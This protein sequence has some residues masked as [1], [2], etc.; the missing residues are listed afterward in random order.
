MGITC[1]LTGTTAPLAL[2]EGQKL[3]QATFHERYEAMP[4]GTR[5]E[6]I[7][8]VVSMPSPVGPEHGRAV[9][10]ALVW[11]SYYQENTPGVDVLDNASTALSSKGEPQP[12]AQLRVLPEY[13]GRTRTERRLVRGVPELI[14]EVSHASRFTDLGPKFDEHERAG[15]LEYVVRAMDPDEILWFA[16]RDGR[17]V[18]QEPA[19]DGLFRSSAFPG[20]WLDPVALLSG[21]TRRLRQVLDQGLSTP[22]H[23]AFA[24]R[25]AAF[26][27]RS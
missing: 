9:V 16:L 1:K 14:V 7:N 21:D 23:A 4:P 6:L 19:A 20:L 24:A 13:G 15:V 3:D 2:V 25:L 8:G 10:P 18:E 22:E 5:A 17:L 12:D 11:L 26:R 27:G